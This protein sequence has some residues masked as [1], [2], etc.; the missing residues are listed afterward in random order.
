M[1]LSVHSTPD[2]ARDAG[3]GQSGHRGPGTRLITLSRCRATT[4]TLL[5]SVG[6]ARSARA[7]T[8]AG[9]RVAGV[10][11]RQPQPALFAARSDHPRQRRAPC[12]WRGS[13]TSGRSGP[14]P[15]FKNE[16]APL[17]VDGTLFM[18]AGINRDVVALDPATG[19]VKWQLD[20]RRGRAHGP[21]AAPQLGPRRVATGATATTPASSSSPRASGWCR[22]TPAPAGRCRRSAADGMVDLKRN[23]GR[24]DFDPL[25]PIGSSSPVVIANGVIVVG[26]ALELG[27]RPQTMANVPGY[28]RGFDVRTGKELWR[29]NTIPQAGE[30]YRRHLGERLV[31]V[32]R[33]RRRVGAVL[34]RRGPGLRLPAGRGADRRS[35]RRASPRRQR[36]LV[37]PGLPRR[38]HRQGGVALPADPPRHLGLR[39]HHRADAARRAQ[40]AAAP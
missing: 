38:A 29:F 13:A 11:R 25:A 15:E 21:G 30:K 34:G 26:P 2:G 33:Q 5:L 3:P 16:A 9:G 14:K 28:V 27:F 4:V 17:Y 12:G 18:T 24:G 10:S 7:R 40:S 37:E 20:A 39:Q 19:A 22:S 31:E 1:L 23:L 32:H 8:G 35:L 6:D 36:L